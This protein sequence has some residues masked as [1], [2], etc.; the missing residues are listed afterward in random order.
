VWFD[1]KHPAAPATAAQAETLPQVTLGAKQE[2][3]LADAAE[4]AAEE[5]AEPPASA[6]DAPN[7]PR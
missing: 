3:A 5:A 1:P 7:D 2:R 4:G 6:E